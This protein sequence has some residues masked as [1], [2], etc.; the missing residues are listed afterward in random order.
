M[1]Y[2]SVFVLAFSFLIS[3][4]AA[5]PHEQYESYMTQLVEH[6]KKHNTD[7]PFA[8]MIIETNSGKELCRGINNSSN[9]PIFHGEIDAIN[10]C[11][12]KFSNKEIDWS[13]LTLITTA[14]PCP[15][16]Q[17]AIIW[18]SIGQVVYGTSIEHLVSL[19]WHQIEI[20]SNEL[21]QRSNFNK[22]NIIAGVL[23]KETNKL[24][25]DF[26]KSA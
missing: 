23:A 12:A 22:P 26:N 15:M 18:S 2:L 6:A 21:T 4:H 19:G 1:K 8:A 16:C 13:K 9:N 3:A 24:F 7:Y 5:S 20:N 25:K 11:V 10:N 14:E 17:G